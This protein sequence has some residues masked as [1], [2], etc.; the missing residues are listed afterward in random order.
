MQYFFTQNFYQDSMHDQ[1]YSIFLF[2]NYS[3]GGWDHLS[4]FTNPDSLH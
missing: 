4:G 2:Q 3:D 1:N